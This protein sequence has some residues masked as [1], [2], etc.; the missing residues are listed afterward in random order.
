VDV[1]VDTG[2]WYALADRSDRHHKAAREFYERQAG[3]AALITTDLILAET[4]AV[5]SARLGQQAALTYWGALREARIP[6][7]APD[8][9]DLEAAWRIA[10]DYSDQSFSFVDCTT[11]AIMERLGITDAFAFDAQFLVYRFGPGRG[12][13]FRRFPR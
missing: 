4:F 9:V 11:F 8:P 3:T 5:L 7:L 6:V 13:G 10:Q 12:Q 2:A 1:L